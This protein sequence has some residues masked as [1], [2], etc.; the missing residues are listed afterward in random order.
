M[1]LKQVRTFIYVANLRSFSKAARA[2]DIAQPAVTRQVQALEEEFRT[3]LLFRTTRGT[4]PTEAGLVLV[5]MGEQML[6]MAEQLREAVMRAPD[7]AKG[8]ATVGMPPSLMPVFALRMLEECKRIFPD[9]TLRVTEGL[10]VFLEEWLSLGRIDMGIMTR[11]E[12]DAEISRTRLAREELVLVAA[13][14]LFDVGVQP[15]PA[16]DLS[17]LILVVTRGFRNVIDPAMATAGLEFTYELELD[18]LP[19]IKEILLRGKFAT[20][21]PYSVVHRE[22]ID[23]TLNMRRIH[24]PELTREIVIGINPHRPLTS[25]MKAVRGLIQQIAREIPFVPP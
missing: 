16:R 13:P 9:V 6:A 23:G 18:S 2:L 25:A 15:L 7:K 5:S 17:K 4:E 10:S 24:E 21:L 11:L 19:I 14:G 3:Q 12:S 1:D 22:V 20:L 8:V